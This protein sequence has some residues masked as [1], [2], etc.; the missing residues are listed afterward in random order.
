MQDNDNEEAPTHGIND[1]QRAAISKMERHLPPNIAEELKTLKNSTQRGKQKPLNQLLHTL[2]PAAIYTNY[3]ITPK[4]D[5]ALIQRFRTFRKGRVVQ[6][7]AS[8]FTYTEITGS[9][10]LGSDAA[11][12][13]G[14]ERGDVVMKIIRNKEMYFMDNAADHE[15][16]EDWTGRSFKGDMQLDNLTDEQKANML[17]DISSMAPQDWADGLAQWV[18]YALDDGIPARSYPP[19]S[20]DA[21]RK[22]QEGY[23]GISMEIRKAKRLAAEAYGNG[24]S[25]GSSLLTLACACKDFT[26]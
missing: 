24:G 12:R 3:S 13:K 1:Y 21:H 11:L 14:L 6:L 20:G 7:G 16:V 18:S 15:M 4:I 25:A 26:K 10:K 8:G 17:N 2:A 5:K 23:D 22:L 9:G 19:A